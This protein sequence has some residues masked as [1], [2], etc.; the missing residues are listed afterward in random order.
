[1]AYSEGKNHRSPFSIALTMAQ[2]NQE[3]PTFTTLLSDPHFNLSAHTFAV[4]T[5]PF[6]NISFALDLLLHDKAAT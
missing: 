4:H 3:I 1:M 5:L 6:H 2:Q